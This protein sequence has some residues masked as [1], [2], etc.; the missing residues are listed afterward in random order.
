MLAA[1]SSLILWT[2]TEFGEFPVDIRSFGTL[3]EDE[4]AG[5]SCEL[6]GDQHFVNC[7]GEVGVRRPKLL[8]GVEPE[9]TG[10]A[11]RMLYDGF[12][13]L[14]MEPGVEAQLFLPRSE[15]TAFIVSSHSG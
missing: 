7:E 8:A 4:E 13:Y 1:R 12:Q 2:S 10:L 14:P 3:A 5:E 15:F 11:L 9:P 6:A